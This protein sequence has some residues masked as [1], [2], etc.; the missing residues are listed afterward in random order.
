[1]AISKKSTDQSSIAA[2]HA[3]AWHRHGMH[4]LQPYL[5]ASLIWLSALIASTPLCA[6]ANDVPPLALEHLTTAEG[7]P[8]GTVMASLQDSR[9]FVWLATED[10]LVRYDGHD[11]IRY[12]YSRTAAKGLPGNFI[13][14][15]VEDERGDLWLPTKDVGLARWNRATDDFTIYRHDATT[16]DSLGS[17]TTRAVLIDKGGRIWVGLRGAGIDILDPST[18]RFQHLRHDV[19]DPSSLADDDIYTLMLDRQG[20]VWVGTA[21]GLDE[22]QPQRH[23]FRHFRHIAGDA[24]T[25]SSNQISSIFEDQHGLIWVGTADAG[26]NRVERGGAVRQVYRHSDKDVASLSSD[27]VRAILEDHQGHLWVGTAEGLDLLDGNE[28]SFIH[29]R[30]NESDGASLRDS[31]VMSLY[32][33]S[34]GLLWIGTRAGG[35]S[36]WN[37]RSWELGSHRPS[38]LAGKL[39]TSFAEAPDHKVWVGSLGGGLVRFDPA[40]G[41]AINLDDLAGVR[42]AVE[43]SR[44]MSLHT[45]RH[46]TLWIGT[47]T[48]G[49]KK[50]S[51]DGHIESIPVKPR[52]SLATS[53][54][55]IMTIFEARSG[56]IW[57][58][59]HGGGVNVLN[60]VSGS[61]RQLPFD[62]GIDGAVSGKDVSA[63]AEDSQGNMWL[64]TDGEGL[65]LARPDGTVV[66]TFRNDPH[67]PS[68]IPSNTIFAIST[69]SESGVWIATAQGGI[70][71]VQGNPS[72]PDSIRFT[73]LSREDGLSGETIY[74]LLND[75]AGHLWMSG[76]AGLMRYDL[77][78]GVIKTYHREHGLQGEEFDFNA[79]FRLPDGRLCFGGPGGFNIFDPARLTRNFKPPAVVLTRLEVLGAAAP[80]ITPYY[81][82]S[83][84]ELDHSASIVS[85]DF[86]ALDFTSP[87]RNR[88]AYR[89][90]GLSDQWIDLGTQHRITLTNLDAGDHNLEVRG[91]NADSVWSDPPLTLTVHRAAPPWRSPFA[92]SL[93]SA[94]VLLLIFYRGYRNRKKLRKMAADTRKL[95]EQV[96]SRTQELRDTNQQLYE[97]SQAK[98]SFLARMSHELRTP[99]NG[100]VG[101]SEL[102]ARTQQ[103]VIQSRLTETIRSSAKVLLHIMNDLLDLSKIQA[104]KIDL[105]SLRFEVL[106]IFEECA[107][108]FAAGAQAK[109]IE[110]VICPPV[111]NVALVG[112]A[113][114]TRQILMNLVG[115]AVKFTE[116]GEVVVKAD[117]G[118]DQ[119]GRSILSMSV[120]D[121]GIGMD[122]ATV[123]KIFEPFTQADESTTRRFGGSGLGLAICRDLAHRM[124]GKIEVTSRLGGGSTFSV[125]LPFALSTEPLQTISAVAIDHPIRLF[126]RR[127]AVQDAMH[128]HALALGTV[129]APVADP[130]TCDLSSPGLI[131]ADLGGCEALIEG[132]LKSKRTP[133]PP[134]LVLASHREWESF[135][136]C[137]EVEDA[138]VVYKPVHRKELYEALLLATGNKAAARPA[139]ETTP[140][141]RMSSLGGHILLVEDE[142]VNAALAQAYL[143]ELGCSSVWVDSGAEAIARSSAE[144]FDL[145]MMDLNMPVMDGFET[146]RL[147]RRHQT[148]DLR[149]P[150]V[151][152]SAHQRASY[153][154]ACVAAGMD[155]MLSKPYTFE[156]CARLI[157]RFVTVGPNAAPAT[158][159][160]GPTHETTT[161]LHRMLAIDDRVVSGLRKL[162]GAGQGD[163]YDQ[164][165]ELFITSSTS[166]I[167]ELRVCLS[168]QQ[169]TNVAG[170][171]H[172]LSAAAANVGAIAFADEARA[173]ERLC[174]EEPRAQAHLRAARL[175]DAHARLCE[176][177]QDYK[178]RASA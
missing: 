155:D 62:K 118:A 61:V 2:A 42:N 177:L 108:L 20:V 94:A 170:L 87:K 154:E 65:D 80:T 71:H 99:M 70:A 52:S 153:R 75:G 57:L 5:C 159:I 83:R 111:Q 148:A 143:A 119:S 129:I 64:G 28:R 60:P 77:S 96:L 171:C 161:S 50:L 128:R 12:A 47:M 44:V 10:G 26:I 136:G 72:K 23:A 116:H 90:S 174:S 22:W 147:I 18:G 173:V 6:R 126:T 92:Y 35:V 51:P 163:L 146:T 103:S 49:L 56:D 69:D 38:W 86:A 124:G 120:A 162:R 78:T 135:A 24:S 175:L 58:G 160:D 54:A 11:L 40:T 137:H 142:P 27:D 164:L 150:I 32:E 31:F 48:R 59:T 107:T 141:M 114:R 132:A 139:M 45:D 74:A 127:L 101:S 39:V 152:I 14:S 117:V 76:N 66:K 73:T 17:D 91:A 123:A 29:Y 25:V 21:D 178:M 102:L 82:L 33:D 41:E 121:T 125:S 112:D 3:A 166:M 151:A 105:E 37:P 4:S 46:Q 13:F 167:Q 109:D 19:A 67:D 113:L 84:I 130:A 43:D 89:V 138:I 176:R 95:E 131:I 15:I 172:K 110:L 53:S 157:R 144:R 55:G 1:M 30:H 16:A 122:S 156:E 133:K 36:R 134:L 93:Y 158:D 81:L 100:V 63:I 104:G 9:G 79:Y 165:V 34:A 145:I 115:N 149:V 68:T 88:L 8:Q 97:A 169:I 7:M 106:P 140:S 168:E 85:L 98:S